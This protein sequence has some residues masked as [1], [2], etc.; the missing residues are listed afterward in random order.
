MADLDIVIP[1][2]NEGDNII[3]VLENFQRSVKT[4]FRV[5]LC[6][7]DDNDNTIPVVRG[8][9]SA[10]FDIVLVKNRGVGVHGAVVS[11]FKMS[12]ADAVLVFPADDTYNAGM[13]DRMV[14]KFREGCDIVCASRFMEGGRMEGCRWLKSA[15]IRSSAFTL[16]YVA[17]VPT[18]DASNG[19]R[20]FSRRLLDSVVIESSVGFTYSIE[21]L[22]KCHR[23]GW[24][25]GEVPALWF[26]RETGRSRFRTVRWLP[27]YLRWYFYGY[28]TTYL[29]KGP[30]SVRLNN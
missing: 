19:L 15:L 9:R 27:A 12:A 20:L 28:A 13:I 11:G 17:R 7:D 1:V 22:V 3:A 23:L 25:I 5:L 18:R 29:N 16:H 6:Y 4:P 24:K 21:L 26:E 30:R 8:Y 2:Y 10:S 14:E